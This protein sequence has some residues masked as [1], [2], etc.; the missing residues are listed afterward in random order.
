[1]FVK[2]IL[3]NLSSFLET[4]NILPQN[5]FGFRKFLSTLQAMFKLTNNNV[6]A[7]N[8]NKK[9]FALFFYLQKA[10]DMVPQ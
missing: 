6:S 4:N 2:V 7:L 10:F 9:G 1:M 8:Q 5:Q 3:N